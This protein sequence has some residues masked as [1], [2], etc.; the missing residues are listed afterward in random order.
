MAITTFDE[1]KT[2]VRNYLDR[3]DLTNRIPE[4]ISLAEDR[5]AK[6][7]RIRAMETSSD[8]TMTADTQTTALPT[9]FLG[10][11]RLYIQ[12]TTSDYRRMEYLTPANFWLR[13]LSDATSIPK[14]YTIE[15]ENFVWA[16]IPDQTYTA[17]LLY[18]QRFAALSSASDT[19]WFLSNA[20]GV[21][22]YGA[23]LEAAPF[24]EDDTRALTWATFYD[25]AVSR[26]IKSDKR[27]RYPEGELMSRSLVTVDGARADASTTT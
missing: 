4:F 22:L 15:G 21:L 9:R 3:D 24:L 12:N 1:L 16:P 13:E 18:Y 10:A 27:D 23:L 6:D 5:A 17:K 20:R 7:L 8:I 26:V 14:L 19:N 2:A 11:I 25:D